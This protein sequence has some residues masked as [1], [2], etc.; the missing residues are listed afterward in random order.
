MASGHTVASNRTFQDGVDADQERIARHAPRQLNGG[1]MFPPSPVAYVPVDNR[2]T[3][4][5]RLG[6]KA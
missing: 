4:F 5:Y 6:W 2:E 3:V 1:N